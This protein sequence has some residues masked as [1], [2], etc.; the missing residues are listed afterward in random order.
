ML[1]GVDGAG[2]SGMICVCA[3]YTLSPVGVMA[4]A[5]PCRVLLPSR[6]EIIDY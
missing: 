2:V 6:T 5:G 1:A 4:S 3:A